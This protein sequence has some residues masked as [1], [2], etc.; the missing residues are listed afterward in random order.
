M[1]EHVHKKIMI[2]DI[3]PTLFSDNPFALKLIE[4]IAACADTTQ[5]RLTFLVDYVFGR[6]VHSLFMAMVETPNVA[7]DK[8]LQTPISLGYL[9]D[10]ML[11]VEHYARITELMGHLPV[12]ERAPLLLTM[13]LNPSLVSP[14]GGS[15]NLTTSE[16]K[17]IGQT[18]VEVEYSKR[19]GILFEGAVFE[20]LRHESQNLVNVGR[21]T[22]SQSIVN[23]VD[24]KGRLVDKE[25]KQHDIDS[26]V[27]YV[28]SLDRKQLNL[29]MARAILEYVPTSK[30]LFFRMERNLPYILKEA[31]PGP[32]HLDPDGPIKN[33]FIELFRSAYGLKNNRLKDRFGA[34]DASMLAFKEDMNAPVRDPV[35]SM[36]ARIYIHYPEHMIASLP[37]EVDIRALIEYLGGSDRSL[38]VYIGRNPFTAHRYLNKRQKRPQHVELLMYYFAMF[39]QEGRIQEYIENILMPEAHARGVPDIFSNEGWPK[40]LGE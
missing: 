16:A 27:E 17:K 1:T 29:F 26:A 6:K 40:E 21:V 24:S 23:P 19:V 36:L 31:Q 3:Q 8:L 15:I 11:D 39:V 2:G 7:V 28:E 34:S 25:F 9:T 5:A 33:G 10:S 32:V 35:I 37:K 14:K 4:Q 22:F 30:G 18:F 38:G 12:V 13:A 20:T